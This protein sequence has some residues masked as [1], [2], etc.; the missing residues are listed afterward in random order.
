M[1]KT[2]LEFEKPIVALEAKLEEMRKYSDN[3][4]IGKEIHEIEGTFSGRRLPDRIL[5]NSVALRWINQGV[6]RFSCF[7]IVPHPS[8]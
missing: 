5:W 2:I 8:K 4:D 7:S 1:A 6:S 3:L